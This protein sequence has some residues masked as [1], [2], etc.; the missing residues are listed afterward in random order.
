VSAG[1]CP[2]CRAHLIGGW[3]PCPRC[4]WQPPTQEALYQW[5]H[6]A[7]LEAKRAAELVTMSTILLAA[8]GIAL[9]A[10][11]VLAAVFGVG[12]IG[13]LGAPL[14]LVIIVAAAV[15]GQIGRAKQGRVI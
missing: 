2:A 4:G 7:H 10:S 15:V 13:M 11:F 12:L 5:Q 8:G 6:A 1:V 9:V 14:S 3:P